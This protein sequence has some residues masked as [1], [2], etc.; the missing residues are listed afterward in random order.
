MT[1]E[2]WKEEV[3]GFV[4]ISWNF[5]VF[6]RLMDNKRHLISL[7]RHTLDS[8][9]KE[10]SLQGFLRFIFVRNFHSRVENKKGKMYIE[11]RYIMCTHFEHDI[12]QRK[13]DSVQ[14]FALVSPLSLNELHDAGAAS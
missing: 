1:R 14:A 2:R 6:L 5:R 4:V 13:I 10:H 11:Y 9:G 7:C 12:I 8:N 3:K